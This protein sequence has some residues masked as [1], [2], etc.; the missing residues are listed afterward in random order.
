MARI[1]MVVDGKDYVYGTYPFETDG[2]KDRVNRIALELQEERGICTY[3]Q[4]V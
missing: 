1:V 3:I 4:E 2:E